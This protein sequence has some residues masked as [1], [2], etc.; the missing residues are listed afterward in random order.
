MTKNPAPSDELNNTLEKLKAL[1]Q[2]IK[3]PTAKANP[4]AGGAPKAGGSPTGDIN[5]TL[6]AVQRGAIGDKVRECW[7][8]DAGALDLE[9]MRVRLTVTTDATGTARLVEVAPEDAGRVDG[10]IRL[11]VFFERARRAILDPRC[12]SLPLPKD[13]LGAIQKLTFVFSP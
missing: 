10:D 9:K 11:K 5:N 7:T 8:K 6:S 2:Q 4:S 3:P 1:Q 12:A 13:K